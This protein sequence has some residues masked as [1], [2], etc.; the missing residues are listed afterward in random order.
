MKFQITTRRARI[1]LLVIWILAL[2]TSIPWS[3]YFQLESLF[4]SHPEVQLCVE[5]WPSAYEEHVYFIVANVIFCYL[6]PLFLILLCYVMIWI[7]VWS[8]SIPT[9][10]NDAHM[11]RLQQRSKVKAR[12]LLSSLHS[13]HLTVARLLQRLLVATFFQIDFDRVRV[14]VAEL[15][16]NKRRQQF[17]MENSHVTVA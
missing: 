1:I 14:A 11:E 13:V 16:A 4:P 5:K 12:Q 7:R 10:N 8:R 2:T 15:V 3:M 9:E 17:L 6:L